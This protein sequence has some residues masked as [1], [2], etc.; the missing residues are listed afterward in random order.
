MQKYIINKENSALM[1]IDIQERLANVMKHR[2]EVIKNTLH[3][4]DLSKLYDIPIIVT[5]QYP[6]GLGKTVPEITQRLN[7]Y[8]ALEKIT[9]DCCLDDE[10]K[11]TILSLNKTHLIITGMET[12]IC[13]LQT[14]LSLLQMGYHC[15]LVC[16]AVCSRTKQNWKTGLS[17]MDKAGAVITSTEIVLFQILQRAGT[18][19]FKT[20][21]KKI[22]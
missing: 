13:V 5:E 15:H 8:T 14:T 7:N 12:H 10:I 16:D 17:L 2:D 21:S 6:K 19:E 4:I 11:K 20:I 3:L 9:F 1:I 18:E 22:K